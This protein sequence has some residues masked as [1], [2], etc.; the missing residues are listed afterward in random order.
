MI[1]KLHLA[2]SVVQLLSNPE[3]QPLSPKQQEVYDNALDV[4]NDALEQEVVD[5]QE[6]AAVE[7]VIVLPWDKITVEFPSQEPYYGLK[8]KVFGASNTEDGLTV[9]VELTGYFCTAERAH[10]LARKHSALMPRDT[11]VCATCHVNT[12]EQAINAIQDAIQEA[13]KLS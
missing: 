7:P 11:R 6:E 8:S 3:L 1:D 4:V 5:K 12:R 9:A 13:C 2:A 10:E